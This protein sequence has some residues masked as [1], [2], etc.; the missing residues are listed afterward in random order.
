MPPS[1]DVLEKRLRGRGTETDE[2]VIRQRLERAKEEIEKARDYDYVI[3]NGPLEECV[4]DV[5]SVINAERQTG[6]RWTG[7]PK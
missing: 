2:N 4:A 7:L 1:M 6:K 5:L 3:V